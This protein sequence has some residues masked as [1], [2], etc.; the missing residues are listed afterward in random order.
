MQ[1]SSA[2]IAWITGGGSGIGQALA[3]RLVREG[4]TVAVSG[5]R[6][7]ALQETARL[8]AAKV[9]AYPLDVSDLEAM[10]Q[11]A[12]RI[13]SELGPIDLVV[14]NAGFGRFVKLDN[15][16]AE[17]FA[18]HMRVNYLGAVNGIDAVLAS[19]RQRHAGHIVIVASVAGYRGLPR[20]AAYGPTKAA[21]IN[22][23]ESLYFDLHR[24]GIMISVCNP[25]FVKTPMTA[26]NRATM[27]FLM[28]LEDACDALYHGIMQRKFEIAFP[29]RF[30]L[31]LKLFRC[32]P[33]A[34]YFPIMR[35]FSG[36]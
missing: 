10:R 18:S 21:L 30:V 8:A 23:A 5:R 7:D 11:T 17:T 13:E 28:D 35:K 22:L 15:L 9:H 29:R 24:E 31:L 34:L 4:W 12:A 27:P 3:L 33:Y 6:P 1:T 19:F 36:R 32:L 16:R 14:L 25:G 20:T 2:R 26:E